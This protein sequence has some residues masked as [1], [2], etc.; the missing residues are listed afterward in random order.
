[1]ATVP[2][3]THIAS[4]MLATKQAD[5]ADD[6]LI[7]LW[8]HGRSDATQRGYRAE[9]KRFLANVRKPL[10]IV[11]LG[12]LQAYADELERLRLQPATR[13]RMLASVKSL[14]AFGHGL[15]YLPF[16]TAKPLRLPPLRDTLAE[17]VIDETNVL[18]MIALEPN[19]RNAAIVALLYGGGLRV[20]ELVALR[21]KHVVPRDDA[22]QVSVLGKG[23]KTRTILLPPSVFRRITALREGGGDEQHVF[24]SRKR[25]PLHP[26]QVLRITKAAA[27]RAGI[28]RNVRN[29]DLRHSHATHSI[30]RG[31]P[32]Q[33]IQATLGHAQIATTG[34]YLHARPNDSSARYL[35]L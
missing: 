11:A 10:R 5:A 8:L 29:H 1:M 30:D 7:E 20:S 18:R 32:L 2:V 22:G 15:G 6:R 25:G 28:E 12:E 27:R 13:R 26:S 4:M 19:P 3:I 31:C 14:F 21:W 9:A 23:S 24:R 35:P 17:R 33:L 34:K 16:D